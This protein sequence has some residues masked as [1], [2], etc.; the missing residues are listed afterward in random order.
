[1][2]RFGIKM[3][4]LQILLKSSL[5]VGLSACNSSASKSESVIEKGE[6]LMIDEIFNSGI[7]PDHFLKIQDNYA[8]VTSIVLKYFKIG[9][10]KEEVIS[11]LTQMQIK[12]SKE[13]DGSIH[14]YDR[15]GKAPWFLSHDDAKTVNIDF[16]FDKDNKLMNIQSRYFIQQ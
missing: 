2:S 14:I 1:V 13:S 8:E 4:L 10:S 6:K 11:K 15:K 12:S 16:K 9:E 5:I 7:K 3:S